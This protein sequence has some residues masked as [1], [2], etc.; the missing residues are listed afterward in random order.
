MQV[1]NIIQLTTPKDT[2]VLLNFNNVIYCKRTNNMHT[3]ISFNYAM[4]NPKKSA[5]LVVKEDFDTI[6]KLLDE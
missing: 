5:F 4:G 1:G 6:L 3:S 2:V